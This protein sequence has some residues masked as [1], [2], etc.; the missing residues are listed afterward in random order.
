MV[1]REKDLFVGWLNDDRDDD[2][3]KDLLLR[4]N[5]NRIEIESRLLRVISPSRLDRAWL[6]M[7]INPNQSWTSR[8]VG[9]VFNFISGPFT[10]SLN[11]IS[12]A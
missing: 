9:K 2:D 8:V 3:E 6:R 12:Q 11:S 5:S 10:V 7:K 1:R 4:H